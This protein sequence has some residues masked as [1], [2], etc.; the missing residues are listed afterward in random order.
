MSRASQSG[1]RARPFVALLVLTGLLLQ[2]PGLVSAH[3]FLVDTTPQ[4]G[5]R[6]GSSPHEVILFFSE[7]IV[8][9]S[10]ELT[11]SDEAGEEIDLLELAPLNGGL[12]VRGEFP[13]LADGVY[14]AS[15]QVMAD[16]SHV[17]AG[18]FAFGV[19][20]VAGLNAQSSTSA[21]S[22]AWPG[23]LAS[24]L[25][26]VGI[27]LSTGGL[28]S[29]RFIWR[30]V[31][32]VLGLE[33]PRAPLVVSLLL[34]LA[35][36]SLHVALLFGSR[37]S[38]GSG[39]FNPLLWLEALSS[40]PGLLSAVTFALVFYG[41]WLVMW[42]SRMPRL[43]LLVL[44]PLL[45][46]AIATA[47]RSHAGSVAEWWVPAVNALHV[48]LAGLWIGALL[49]L[50][51]VLWATRGD[52]ALPAL[53]RAAQRYAGL[54]LVLVSPL[55][56][57]GAVTALAVVDR[58]Q[59]LLTTT[60]GRVLSLKLLLVVAVLAL[61]LVARLRALAP[62]LPKLLRRLTAAE[63]A[64][65]LAV[66]ALSAVLANAAPP[67]PRGQALNELLG[68]AP[69]SGPVLR[70]AD[71]PGQ[72][73]LFLAAAE[74]QLQL[75]VIEPGGE[76]SEGAELEISGRRPDGLTFDLY[77]RSCGPG[78][79]SMDVNWS[80]GVTSF[81][82]S[83]S[84]D[85]WLGG[86]AEF[87]VPWPPGEDA[88]ERLEAVIEAMGEL[89]AFTMT[90]RVSSGPD[91]TFSTGRFRMTNPFFITEEVYANGGATDVRLLPGSEP[92]ITE[93]VLFLPGSF[94]WY[95]L[96]VDDRNRLVRELIVNPGHRIERTFSYDDAEP[97]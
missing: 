38:E 35:G 53:A 44:L 56:I 5:E 84:H 23:A 32:R 28:I 4:A 78:C 65:L 1:F 92:G 50:V 80:E 76:G 9:G 93:I 42:S 77:P 29:E 3:A 81:S 54:A 37:D 59:Q 75:R 71:L 73:A 49:H 25:L 12:W 87:E 52:G 91:A 62:L 11:V 33:V 69:L 86:E 72:L 96:S 89:P 85:E 43:R 51:Q 16:D 36:V 40:R 30:P 45:A 64:G 15:W 31:Q 63:G 90:E 39:P 70:L 94:M 67:P 34:A 95:K 6:L 14:R 47:Y 19:G 24:F 55:L 22:V 66:V 74:G 20:D 17:S 26:L 79:F 7:P 8:S 41:L 46:A 21:G 2:A 18:E 97:E 27:V 13:P 83:V 58:P 57:A 48:L 88:S 60:Y 68:P 10:E 82:V 61:A